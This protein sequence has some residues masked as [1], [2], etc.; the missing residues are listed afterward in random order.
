MGDAGWQ[1]A[2]RASADAS[3]GRRARGER[4][5]FGR[6]AGGAGALFRGVRRA[7]LAGDCG[8][9]VGRQEADDGF[10]LSAR[11][12]AQERRQARLTMIARA[13]A[14]A[15]D[16]LLKISTT[17]AHSDELLRSREVD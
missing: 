6:S 8:A 11:P 15:F 13:R 17:D 14:A 10:G 7:E 9:A 1:K 2:D 16:I 5:G 12:C 4:C 3:R